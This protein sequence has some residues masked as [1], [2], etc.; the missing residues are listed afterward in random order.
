LLIDGSQD[1]GLQVDAIAHGN[2]HFLEVERRLGGLFLS[3]LSD[4]WDDQG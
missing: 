1:H 2:H 4:G 3:F